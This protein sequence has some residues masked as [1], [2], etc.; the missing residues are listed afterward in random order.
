ML[1]HA[2]LDGCD[3]IFIQVFDLTPL[4]GVLIKASRENEQLRE[5]ALSP[6]HIL[7]GSISSMIGLLQLIDAKQLDKE[8]RKL[9]GYLRQLFKE[10]DRT[11]RLHVK[12]M[13]TFD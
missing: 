11:I 3:G 5:L 10:L 7:R 2:E 1:D 13:S 9:F 6:S 8:N 12:K 4:R